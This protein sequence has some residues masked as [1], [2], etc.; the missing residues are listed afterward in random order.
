[1]PRYII[2]DNTPHAADW[3]IIKADTPELA[4]EQF[5]ASDEYYRGNV[6]LVAEICWQN[7]ATD[8]EGER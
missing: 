1:M 7:P 3:A 8:G 6:A 2:L 5:E 4:R